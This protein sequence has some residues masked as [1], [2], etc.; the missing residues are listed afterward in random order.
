MKNLELS[1]YYTI[2]EIHAKIV[3]SENNR[4]FTHPVNILYYF[5]RF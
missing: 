2:I 4:L 1:I 5:L 3:E